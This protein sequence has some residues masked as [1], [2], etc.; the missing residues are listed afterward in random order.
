MM[1]LE[2]HFPL[3]LIYALK[4]FTNLFVQCCYYRRYLL[5]VIADTLMKINNST[6]IV[7]DKSQHSDLDIPLYII[8][9]YKKW[10]QA[11]IHR[12]DMCIAGDKHVKLGTSVVH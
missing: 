1:N 9:M 3:V 2:I 11:W 4:S 10:C 8:F 5:V 6:G 12:Y 7:Q